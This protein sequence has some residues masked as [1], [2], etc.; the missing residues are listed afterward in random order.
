MFG[1]SLIAGI[2][3][4]ASGALFGQQRVELATLASGILQHTDVARQAIA[5]RDAPAAQNHIRQALEMAGKIKDTFAHISSEFD[6]VSTTV[7]SK[8]H[9]SGSVSEVN[10]SYTTTILNVASAR[11][12]L[13]AAQAA[14]EKGDLDAAGTDLAAVQADVVTKTFNGDLPLVQAKDNLEIALARVREGKYKDAILPLKS[15]ARALDRFA[16]QNPA[17]QPADVVSRFSIEIDAY[18][19]RITKDHADAPDRV[20]A[21]LNQVTDWFNSGMAL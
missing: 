10:G 8:R 9:G 5:H 13:L 16:H 15:A 17:P 3:L 21:W 6:T 1:K 4:L 7:S 11:N 14:L 19:E 18:A 20:T 2:A 12:H